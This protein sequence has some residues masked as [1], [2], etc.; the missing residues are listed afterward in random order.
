MVDNNIQIHVFIS[1]KVQMVGYRMWT[2]AQAE[3]LGLKGWVKNLNDGRVEAV[4]SGEEKTVNNMIKL[5]HSGPRLAEV[6][7]VITQ[8]EVPEN[9][10]NFEIRY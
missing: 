4:F 3:K 7:E 8:S 10:T 6:T 5:C 9:F 1:G 2:V